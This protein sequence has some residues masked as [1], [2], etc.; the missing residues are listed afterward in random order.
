MNYQIRC[1]RPE[2]GERLK[3]YMSSLYA[4][5]LPFL[6][7][8][9]ILPTSEEVIQFIARHSQT[10]AILFLV[11]SEDERIVGMLDA[12][13]HKHHQRSHCASFGMSLLGEY[14]RMGIGNV[15]LNELLLWAKQCQLKRLELEVF[16]NN[17]AA[18]AL[19]KKVGFGVEGTKKAAVQIGSG[20]VDIFLM[21]YFVV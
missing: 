12:I 17:L 9:N 8:R 11:V 10:D 20:F 7:S 2:D 21:A 5:R 4:E 15:L 3:A 13:I 6:Y 14:R 19:Y 18:V 1:A 16:A